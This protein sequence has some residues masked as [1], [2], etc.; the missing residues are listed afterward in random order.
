MAARRVTAHYR[1]GTAADAGSLADLPCG[2][3]G[4]QPSGAQ[5]RVPSSTLNLAAAFAKTLCF[6][7]GVGQSSGTV[8]LAGVTVAGSPMSF[9]LA[10]WDV[11][12]LL[13]VHLFQDV[14]V[15]GERV[16]CRPICRCSQSNACIEKVAAMQ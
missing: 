8:L 12:R 5:W 16:C 3:A 2:H 9:I 1:T 7:Y 11:R 14:V 15:M 13:Y 4:M 10:L 6:K